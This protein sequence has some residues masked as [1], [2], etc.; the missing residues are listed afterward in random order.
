MGEQER[1]KSP[2]R[3]DGESDVELHYGKNRPAQDEGAKQ[4]EDKQDEGPDVEAHY[5]KNRP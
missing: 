1:E 2:R 5:G 4:P 3:T